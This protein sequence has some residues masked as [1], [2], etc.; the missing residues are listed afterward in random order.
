MTPSTLAVLGGLVGAASIATAAMALR[1]PA[2]R[3]LALRSAGRRPAETVLVTVGALLGTAIITGSLIVG[4]SLSGSIRAGAFTHLG[5]IDETVTAPDPESLPRLRRPLS[6]LEEHPSVDGI[7]YGLR[8]R[9]T[10]TASVRGDDPS[11]VPDVLLMEL[12]FA[13]ARD[14]G[15][16]REATGL[17]AV[18]TPGAGEVAISS[19]L[20]RELELDAGDELSVFAYG[21]RRRFEVT[22][23]LPEVGLAGYGTGLGAE[24]FDVFLRPGTLAG[25]ADAAPERLG[26]SPPVALAFVSN[27]GGV[28]EGAERSEQVTD[29]I[30][31]RIAPLPRVGVAGSKQE[32]LDDADEL[33]SQLSDIFLGVGSFAVVAGILLLVNIFVMLAAE[34]RRELGIMRAVGMRRAELV[35]AFFLEG[36]L[37]SGAAAVVGAVGGIGVG[38]A[39][40]QLAQ[41]I[42]TGAATG[43]LDLR[44]AADATSVAGGLLVGLVISLATVLVTSL[45]IS[46]L[47]VVRAI[48]EL[49]EPPRAT[50]R[51]RGFV[52]G[53]LGT[54]AG[55]LVTGAAAGSE[56][57]VGLLLGP[58]V[59]AA[60]LVPLLCPVVG[61]RTAV[62]GLGLLVVVWGVSAPTLLSGAF[63]NGEVGVF[64]VQGLVI[65]GAA[66]LVLGRNQD[67]LGRLVRW[68]VGGTSS[69]TAR[70]GLAYPL[71]RPFRTTMTLAMY[72]LV[73]FT[74]VL[75]SLLSE[76][77]GGQ[78]SDV[79]EAESGGYDLVVDSAPANPL[80]AGVVRDLDGVAGVAPLRYAASRVEFRAPG[81]G[82]FRRWF[83]SGFDRELLRTR[84][85]SLDRWSSDLAD[86]QVV[87]EHVLE[88][89]STMIVGSRFLQEGGSPQQVE[90]G[91]V[92]EMRDPVTGVTAQRTVV[93]VM[94]GG[95][96]FSGAFMAQEGLASVLGPRVPTN[97][98]YVSVDEDASPPAVTAVL[99]ARHIAHGV[100]ARTFREIVAE[101]QG[102]NLQ[103]LRILQGYLLLGL[104]VGTAGLGVVMVR[105]VR[106]RRRQIGL[107]RSIGVQ[108]RAVG[109][110]FMLEGA[111]IALQGIVV[112]TALATATA[113]QLITNA[114]VLGGIE[115][116]FSVPWTQVVVLLVVTLMAT[117]VAAGWPARRAGRIR[118]AET[119]RAI[120]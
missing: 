118:P 29:L 37:Y 101:R 8:A 9:G 110:T 115:V 4:D 51:M 72:A 75:V 60:G 113:Y 98:L 43:P 62:T 120:E 56:G 14:F 66:V 91:D 12:D 85:P 61:R 6:G 117:A 25:L 64:V 114:A 106:E 81:G 97:R 35:R 99:E 95:L 30:R 77:L 36:A 109:R 44:F 11:V 80:P 46:R 13:D 16:D 31:D 59:L 23:V 52:V 18:P 86:E 108:A 2:A 87:W 47:N 54:L 104:L 22:D 111:F 53:G 19:G 40:M 92:V 1:R 58:A 90:I 28:L 71:A 20:A 67:A 49:P 32:L 42:S 82:E 38:A 69:V 26:A 39:I 116:G 15:G 88:N 34:R 93:G 78:V 84:P 41:G 103:F 119:L 33:A 89:P 73:V 45:R 63:R 100:E 79:T 21:A 65:T 94:E 96:A 102:Q 50:R 83:A 17:D 48:R 107:L 10:V 112:G 74:L 57:G 5:P 68:V 3:R 7:T 105:A 24:A 76:V 70:L 27:E 55:L